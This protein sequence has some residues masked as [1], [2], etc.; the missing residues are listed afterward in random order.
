MAAK[1]RE[2]TPEEAKGHPLYGVK[3]WLLV[4]GV[5][6]LLQCLLGWGNVA[7]AARVAGLTI[8]DAMNLDVPEVTALKAALM[9]STAQAVCIIGLMWAKAR[10]FRVFSSVVLFV[11]WPL[12][13]LVVFSG[14]TSGVVVQ[15]L[16]KSLF[17]WVFFCAVWVTY[18]NRSRRVR[19]TFENQVRVDE[20]TATVWSPNVRSQTESAAAAAKNA[21]SQSNASPE[22]TGQPH[23]SVYDGRSR[24]FDQA[25]SP[26]AAPIVAE[27]ATESANV[28]SGPPPG[29]PGEPT[30]AHWAAALL[31]LEGTERRAGLWAKSF[32]GAGGVEAAAKAAYLSD[33]TA[34]LCEIDE[35][36]ARHAYIA[37]Q[38]ALKQEAAEAASRAALEQHHKSLTGTFAQIVEEL[39]R[40]DGNS[41]D[42]LDA[43][44][45]LVK[46][47]GGRVVSRSGGGF[48]DAVTKY[49]VEMDKIT[50]NF[51]NQH[52]L[53]DWVISDVVPRARASLPLAP[54]N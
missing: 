23:L 25:A 54:V 12:L 38:A 22:P 17:Q 46:L 24:V 15:A 52:A 10:N 39:Q 11:S 35:T 19:V 37:T 32:A 51:H 26:V 1:W 5:G 8:A 2:V 42:A 33:R 29:V 53:S 27:H 36:A 9:V 14:N 47:M 50:R 45:S 34:Q 30:E 6:Q 40:I 20:A 3:G 31:E 7:T 43:T 21:R 48:G 18:L 28:L 44:I 13:A 41:S 16:A 49:T 4:F